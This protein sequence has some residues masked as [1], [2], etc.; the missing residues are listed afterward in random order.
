[1]ID[2]RSG[3]AFGWG[4]MAVREFVVKGML[5]WLLNMFTFSVYFLIDSFMVFGDRQR[6]LHDRMVNSIVRQSGPQ[7]APLDGERGGTRRLRW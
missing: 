3:R 2:A 7:C 1:V 4:E 6:T 5:G